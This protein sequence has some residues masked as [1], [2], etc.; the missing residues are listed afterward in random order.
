MNQFSER[1]K[2]FEAKFGHDEEMRFK[3]ETRRN[4]LLGLWAAEQI[5][6]SGADADAYARAVIETDYEEPGHDDVMRKV[7]KDLTDRKVDATEHIVRKKMDELMDV[8]MAQ[9]MKEVPTE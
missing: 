6:L 5:G 7:L 9:V 3:A 1:E 2:A 8:A 4:K